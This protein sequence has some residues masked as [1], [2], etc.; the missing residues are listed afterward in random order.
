MRFDPFNRNIAE[1]VTWYGDVVL[2]QLIVSQT[3]QGV[4]GRFQMNVGNQQTIDFEPLL[5]EVK[6]AAL[7]IQQIRRHVD[8]NLC[9][10]RSS[11]LLHCFL[12]QDAQDV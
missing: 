10:D 12:L 11:V 4:M 5:H 7:F 2:V 6:L 8:W 1:C 3:S 9:M